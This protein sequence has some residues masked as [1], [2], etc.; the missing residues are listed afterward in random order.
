MPTGGRYFAATAG[1]LALVAGA[2]VGNATPD[3]PWSGELAVKRCTRAPLTMPK[4]TESA[5]VATLLVRVDDAIGSAVLISPD[6]FALTAAHVVG[7]AEKVT[8]VTTRKAELE[9]A[10]VRVDERSD[11]ALLKV[12]FP[13]DAPCLEPIDER[14]PIGSDIFVLG[15]PG[16]EELA[17][18][19]AKGIVS[20]YRDFSGVQFVQLDASVNPGNSGGAVVDEQGRIVGLASWKVSHVSMEGLAFAVPTA[21]ALAALDLRATDATDVSWAERG[22]RRRFER[23]TRPSEQPPEPAPQPPQAPTP[24]PTITEAPVPSRRPPGAAP[25]KPSSLRFGLVLSGGIVSAVGL[26]GILGTAGYYWS[27]D[28]MS[29]G[30]WDAMKGINTAGW[31]TMSAG[32]GLLTTGLFL[33]PS[34]SRDVGVAI[35]AGPGGVSAMGT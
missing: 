26:A 28:D 13:V 20:G 1:L 24:T 11:V 30:T 2:S 14:T 23:P 4:E 32:V 35:G 12:G 31:I 7:E 19:V 18:S 3:Q 27:S 10:V 21:G 9:A 5:L 22:G 33:V 6:G 8:V 29:P 34:R 17:F 25:E 16:G 15:S